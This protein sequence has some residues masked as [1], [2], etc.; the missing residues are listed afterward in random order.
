MGQSASVQEAV[1]E[2]D[3]T[4]VVTYVERDNGKY[5]SE[6]TNA[7]TARAAICVLAGP[8]KTGKTTLYRDICRQLRIEPVVVHC[9]D[10]M[11]VEQVWLQALTAV[12]ATVATKAIS[13]G[14]TIEHENSTLEGGVRLPMIGAK[15]SEASGR[16]LV[17]SSAWE[18]TR[19]PI[20][21]DP[22]SLCRMWN[23][24]GRRVIVFED[25][26]FLKED[27]RK[28]IYE[29]CK[30]LYE[31]GVSA[32]V[33]CTA[34]SAADVMYLVP[35]L[36][37]RG[38]IIW[39]SSWSL[40]DLKSIITKGFVYLGASI[41]DDVVELIARESV[42]LPFLTQKICAEMA[43][44]RLRSA[45]SKARIEEQGPADATNGI[46]A[47]QDALSGARFAR[48]DATQAMRLY[49]G[50]DAFRLQFERHLKDTSAEDQDIW[51]S[52]QAAFVCGPL[53]FSL[54][55]SD[56]KVRLRR[57]A[58]A[59]DGEGIDEDRYS[60]VLGQMRSGKKLPLLELRG[61]V[62]YMTEPIF[63]F[64]LRWHEMRGRFE[65]IEALA[66]A[67]YDD[68]GKE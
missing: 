31:N 56:A 17:W 67:M 9:A 42:G 10:A 44:K 7:L 24:S 18:Y 35:D 63:L 29:Q 13:T 15:A 36:T 41:E 45:G 52:L 50:G 53:V 37:G 34:H 26:H 4:P 51:E 55:V 5:E 65:E 60:D 61:D 47:Q 49:A 59:A 20:P 3:G 38:A 43:R 32:I 28:S 25:T 6:L 11:S 27:V 68:I 58:T 22:T 48:S 12:D 21:P 64:Y 23:P 14:T 66:Q 57:L 16:D 19:Y 40:S 62:L 54:S 1:F 33:V 2:P 46:A 39:L 30:A 8:S